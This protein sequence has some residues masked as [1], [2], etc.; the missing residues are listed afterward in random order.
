M[1]SWTR[2]VLALA[3]VML[4]ASGARG[5]I[6]NGVTGTYYV[7]TT[8]NDSNLGTSSSRPFKTI[9]KA[10]NTVSTPGAVIYVAP[11]TYNEQITLSTTT[12]AGTTP[13]PVR[14]IGDTAGTLT[15]TAA[16]SVVI[17]GGGTRSY[18]ILFNGGSNWKFEKLTFRDQTSSNVYTAV[19]NVAGMN[20][21]SCTFYV[22]P[23]YGIYFANC[24]N[25]TLNLC[26]FVRSQASGNVTYIYQTSGTTQTITRNRLTM[27]GTDYL[28][29]GYRTGSL[30]GNG[31]ATSGLGKISY[32]II[33]M[34]Y[35]SSGSVAVTVTNNVVSDAFLG[36]YIYVSKAASS[37]SCYNNT[38]VGSYYGLYVY[39]VDS[40]PGTIANN[41]VG[42][43]YINVYAM[44]SKCVLDSQLSWGAGY[45]PCSPTTWAGCSYVTFKSMNNVI[46]GQAPRFADASAG[47][48]T[49]TGMVGVDVG[50][51]TGAPSVDVAGKARP[52][53][54]DGDGTAK[55]DL[56]AFESP[57]QQVSSL[58]VIR[59][60]EV[61]S[62]E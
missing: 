3:A 52:F 53:D 25:F 2:L 41:V 20:F 24:G 61:G 54:S 7:S 4:G 58:R 27:T 30:Y 6:A 46:L 29:S 59:W 57:L 14:L 35:P 33:A 44:A 17:S 45:D 49:L 23:S 26:T 28:S 38:V 16:G 22:A 47:D 51:S 19:S 50:L 1:K 9:Q 18:G 11:G 10:V 39:T 34:A 12:R 60:Q 37:I 13:L 36:I 32:G 8:G 21:D 56:G 48:F 42:D 15:G 31:S 40:C 5:Q 55:I 62:D 43:C